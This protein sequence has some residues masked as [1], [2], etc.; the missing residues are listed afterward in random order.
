MAI[1]HINSFELILKYNQMEMKDIVGYP[2]EFK[3]NGWRFMDLSN[4]YR[5]C[6]S[7]RWK[8]REYRYV[9]TEE[10]IYIEDIYHCKFKDVAGIFNKIRWEDP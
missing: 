1:K 10:I 4:C 8:N 2:K 7:S 9:K 3:L 5:P 6:M